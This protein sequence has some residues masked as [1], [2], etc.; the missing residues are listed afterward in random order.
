MPVHVEK[1]S[2][3][4]ILASCLYKPTSTKF[5]LACVYGDPHHRKTRSAWQEVRSFV[6]RYPNCPAL[7]TGVLNNIMNA[8]EKYGPIQ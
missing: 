7:C 2:S 4:F 8:N 3:N 1:S 5:L 6:V